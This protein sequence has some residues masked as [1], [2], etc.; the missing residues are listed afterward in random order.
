MIVAKR[1]EV[2]KKTDDG[3]NTFIG[4]DKKERAYIILMT[5]FGLIFAY[6]VVRLLLVMIR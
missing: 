4:K 5:T 1:R 3:K 6:G 2:T